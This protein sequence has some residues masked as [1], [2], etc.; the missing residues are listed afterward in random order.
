[1]AGAGAAE[2]AGHDW[3]LKAQQK[4]LVDIQRQV[5]NSN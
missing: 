1:M 5:Y 3:A 2:S 4:G